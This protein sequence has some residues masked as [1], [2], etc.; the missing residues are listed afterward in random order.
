MYTKTAFM[1][2]WPVLG[3]VVAACMPDPVRKAPHKYSPDPNEE[4]TDTKTTVNS[5]RILLGCA[6]IAIA[7][8]GMPTQALAASCQR[9]LY[10]SGLHALAV[11]ARPSAGIGLNSSQTAS[12]DDDASHR[13][14]IVGLW[15]TVYTSGGVT[16]FESFD[17]W[18]ADG[19]EFEAAELQLGAMCQGTW[20]KTAP[21]TV[22]LFHVG[23][24]F[25]PTGVTLVGYFTE[26]QSDTLSADGKT[27]DGTFAIQNFDLTGKH[28][29]GQDQSGTVHATRFTV[30]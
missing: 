28:I 22:R 17:Q 3:A 1:S 25:D 16:A 9:P 29:P 19:N 18:H 12:G 23:W 21:G 20:E 11:P 13:R 8:W 26:I 6:G 10:A 15:H 24:N 7:S 4:N 2:A 14:S 27:Y 5:L 30:P